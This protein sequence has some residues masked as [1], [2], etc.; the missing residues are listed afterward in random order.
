[1]NRRIVSLV[2]AM[3][4]A[5]GASSQ[6][7]A[8]NIDLTGFTY[9]PAAIATVQSSA[10]GTLFAPFAVYAGQYTGTMDGQSF[11]T[12][13]VELTQTISFNR[14]YTD[15]T[16]VSGVSAWGAA[17]SEQFDRVISAL[18]AANVAHDPNG[19]AIAQAAIWE[20]LYETAPSAGFSTGSFTFAG[21]NSLSTAVAS[22]DWAAIAATPIRYHVDLLASPSAQDLLRISAVPEP[23]SF[24]LLAAG[25][26]GFGLTR[27]RRASQR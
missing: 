7:A 23:A 9:G 13:C 4:L 6:A 24:A 3:T 17:K 5:L 14:L 10:P 22:M 21:W 18:F 26:L 20:T 15:Y 25:L 12:Y 19:S 8:A 16:L 1:M 2:A 27:R 11:I